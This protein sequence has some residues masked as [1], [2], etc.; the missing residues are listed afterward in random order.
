MARAHRISPAE[1]KARIRIELDS[2]D[3]EARLRDRR[4]GGMVVV[5]YL[6]DLFEASPLE[7]FSRISV[8]SVLDRVRKD[9]DLFPPASQ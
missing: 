1:P 6:Y 5:D 8:L 3:R 7:A 4:I 2:R 9:R